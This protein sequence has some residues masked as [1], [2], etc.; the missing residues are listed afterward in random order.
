[1]EIAT[2]RGLA[3]VKYLIDPGVSRF[4]VQAFATG[5]LSAF[6]HNP[7]IGIRD[8]EGQIQFVP[9]TYEKSFVRVVVQTGAMEVLDEMKNDDRKKLEQTMFDEVLNLKHFPTAV[10][11]SKDIAVQKLNNSELLQAHVVGDLTFHGMTQTHSF[12]AR[13]SPME[14]MMRMS[15]EFPLRQSDYGIK[16][17]SFAGGALRLKDEV[18][19]TFELVARRQ[20]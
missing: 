18:K 6:G 20:E 14:T 17:V 16:P 11:E 3:T 9:D 1:M 5:L 19:F 12:D 13:V 10:F 8:Y 15:G 4:T 2:Q 7:K